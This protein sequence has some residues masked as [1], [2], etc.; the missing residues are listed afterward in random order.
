MNGQDGREVENVRR[1]CRTGEAVDLSIFSPALN[2]EEIFDEIVAIPFPR[3]RS[4]QYVERDWRESRQVVQLKDN[5]SRITA[6][7]G[8]IYKIT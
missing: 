5:Y 3:I 2:V 4:R 8:F 7:E 6:P 1:N